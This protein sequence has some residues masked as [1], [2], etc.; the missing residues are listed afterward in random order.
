MQIRRALAL[1]ASLLLVES[2]N[3]PESAESRTNSSFDALRLAFVPNVGQWNVAAEF[4][5]RRGG[6]LAR[7]ENDALVLQCEGP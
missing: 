6:M 7:L 5:V 3:V 2:G 1:F 4:V